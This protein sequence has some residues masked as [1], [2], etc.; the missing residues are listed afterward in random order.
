MLLWCARGDTMANL[1]RPV[2]PVTPE[3]AEVLV[4]KVAWWTAEP[5]SLGRAFGMTREVK[6]GTTLAVDANG[7]VH[8]LLLGGQEPNLIRRR[9]AFLRRQARAG[10]LL[11]PHHGVGPDGA[12]LANYLHAE[13]HPGGTRFTG[14]M[15][16]L[17]LL[18]ELP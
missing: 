8:A 6:I 3:D 7:A 16:A 2:A 5:N 11:A 18:E 10:L 12:M 17:H 1:D 13:T 4:I 9:D 14:G 15:R